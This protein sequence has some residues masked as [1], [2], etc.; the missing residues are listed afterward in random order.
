MQMQLNKIDAEFFTIP[1]QSGPFSGTALSCLLI[2]LTHT[3]ILSSAPSFFSFLADLPPPMLRAEYLMKVVLQPLQSA[4]LDR[5]EVPTPVKFTEISISPP[6][7]ALLADYN[8]KKLD[9]TYHSESKWKKGNIGRSR[10]LKE[11]G[12]KTRKY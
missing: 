3:F 9:G 5:S 7:D 11:E 2:I 4:G 8:K 12:G 1:H 6:L 10:R